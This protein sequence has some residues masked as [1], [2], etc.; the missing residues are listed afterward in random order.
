MPRMVRLARLAQLPRRH[1][2]LAIVAALLVGAG[3]LLAITLNPGQPPVATE[4]VTIS[5]PAAP[6]S[7]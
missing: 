2:A 1:V 4:N 6:G 3:V 5:V 7:T